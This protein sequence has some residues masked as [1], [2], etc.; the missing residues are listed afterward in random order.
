MGWYKPGESPSGERTAARTRRRTRRLSAFVSVAVLVCSAAVNAPT[1]Q[2]GAPP[3]AITMPPAGTLPYS[4]GIP[5]LMRRPAVRGEATGD[6]AAPGEGAPDGPDGGDDSGKDE[7]P[8]DV[9]PELAHDLAPL[10]ADG[11]GLSV[12]VYDTATRSSGL[13][14][15]GAYDTASIVKVDILTALLLQAQRAGR[16]LTARERRY[17]AAMIER[18][19]N[20]AATALWRR[21]GGA[22]ALNAVNRRLGLRSTR[23]GAGHWWGLTRTT[24][25][26]QLALLRS[27]FG[28]KSVL[29]AGRRKYLMQLMGHVEPDQAWGVS[30][31]ADRATVSALKNGWLMRS[32]TGLWDVNSIG[33]VTYDGHA[34]L[35]VVLSNGNISWDEGIGRVQQ[36]A[37]IAVRAVDTD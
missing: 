5:G 30:A 33:R 28:P 23:G 2:R 20:T 25:A 21:I 16:N 29:S 27:V 7:Q 9:S 13:Y 37:R 11:A 31:A 15:H 19:D 17:A 6:S 22:R 26:D 12:A 1:Q 4:I 8:R 14:G 36:A 32:D 24:A 18:S 10:D 35:V 34:M 3:R